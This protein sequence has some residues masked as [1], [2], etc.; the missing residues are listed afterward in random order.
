[1]KGYLNNPEADAK[2]LKGGWFMTGNVGVV[3]PDG[4]IK[5]KD[6]SKDVIISGGENICSKDLEHVLLQHPAVADTAVV[7]M[8]HWLWGE[9]PCAFLVAKDKAA[10]VCNDEV[11]AFCRE[12]S[13]KSEKLTCFAWKLTGLWA[14]IGTDT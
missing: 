13:N 11:V 12:R 3:H 9:T 14:Y 7:G 5:I 6:R 8:P 4:Y 1:M 2:A 10:E